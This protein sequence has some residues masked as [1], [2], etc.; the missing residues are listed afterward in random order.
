[1]TS[2]SVSTLMHTQLDSRIKIE[3]DWLQLQL[4][5]MEDA[6]TLVTNGQV[7]EFSRQWIRMPKVH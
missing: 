7:S 5:N 1:M 6:G 3:M 2:K 4:C